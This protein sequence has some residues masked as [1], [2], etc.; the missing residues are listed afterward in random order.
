VLLVIFLTI[1]V[2]VLSRLS[3]DPAV[4][5]LGDQATPAAIARLRT[6]LGLDRP[7]P[8][9]Y[10]VFFAH[11]LRGD[12]GRSLEFRVPVAAVL[13]GPLWR[14]AVLVVSTS[15]IVVLVAVPMGIMGAMW[16]NRAADD[17][18][19]AWVSVLQGLPVFWL[20]LLLIVFFGLELGWLPTS[21]YGGLQHLILPACTLAAYP[22]ASLS[23][24]LRSSLLEVLHE[25]YIRTARAKSV[26]EHAILIRHALRPAAPPVLTLLALQMGPLIGSA[27]VTESVFAWPGLGRLTLDAVLNR[28]FPLV[29]GC[30]LLVVAIVILANLAADLAYGILDPRIRY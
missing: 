8:V 19:G 4:L 2:F 5:L 26:P 15:V 11:L 25:D 28:D 9:Q 10:L 17:V 7:Y 16:H 18:L 20:G 22:I 23:R 1:I 21:G 30:V 13:L 12:L 27:I 3:G 6:T 14:S 29:Q 24:L